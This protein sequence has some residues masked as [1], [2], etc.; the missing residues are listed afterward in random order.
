MEIK[1]VNCLLVLV[2]LFLFTISGF[3]SPNQDTISYPKKLP[4][5]TIREMVDAGK[6]LVKETKEL[7]QAMIS[8]VKDDGGVV[9]T[10]KRHQKFYGSIFIFGF[11][12]FIWLKT[13]DKC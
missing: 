7:G 5:T 9:A 13:R 4:E 12:T 1:K 2:C 6:G 11:L 8:G 10:V 3:S